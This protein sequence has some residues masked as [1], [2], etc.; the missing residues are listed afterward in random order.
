MNKISLTLALLALITSISSFFYFNSHSNQVYVDVN[1]LL[2]GYKRTKV[3]RADFDATAKTLN[4]NVDS[5]MTNWQTEL[6]LYEKERSK[7]SDKELELKQ[8]LLGN[9]QQQINNYQ[10]AIQ[11]QIDE[12]DKKSTQTV[13]N[14]IND[15][16]KEYGKRNDYDIIFGAS[17]SGSIMYASEKADLTEKVLE[18]L[19][20]E[21]DGK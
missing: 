19:N 18:G 16:V 8:E 20:T 21:F 5:L 6:K 10:Q 1:K 2:E 7:M 14:D 13:I 4:A 3:V 11:K 17:G 12:S 15:Y 9:K